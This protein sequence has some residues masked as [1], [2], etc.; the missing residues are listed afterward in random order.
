MSFFSGA[1]GSEKNFYLVFFFS[2]CF[3]VINI[4]LEDFEEEKSSIKYKVDSTE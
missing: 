4:T 3:I 1:E 2:R